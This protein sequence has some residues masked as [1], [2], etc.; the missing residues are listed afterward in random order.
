MDLSDSWFMQFWGLIQL[1]LHFWPLLFLNQGIPRSM[2]LFMGVLLLFSHQ[3]MS[4][5]LGYRGLQHTRPPCPSP[6]PRVCTSSFCCISDAIQ[7]SHPLLPSS[8]S[9]FN[10][11]Q[12]Q[13]LFQS[14]SSSHQVANVW[15]FSFSI[16][17]SSEY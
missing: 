8:P 12:Y 4:D 11:S 14:V 7:P 15:S 17:P 6:S 13:G 3:V 10:L 1:K 16:N 2:P 9:A 5:S